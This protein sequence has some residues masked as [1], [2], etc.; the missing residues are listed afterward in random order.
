MH[1][2]CTGQLNEAELDNQGLQAQLEDMTNRH[3]NLTTAHEQTTT[4]K[5]ELASAL[6]QEQATLAAA[7]AEVEACRSQIEELNVQLQAAQSSAGALGE[8]ESSLRKQLA[9]VQTA[10]AEKEGH[11]AAAQE[12]AQVRAW[13]KRLVGLFQTLHIQPLCNTLCLLGEQKVPSLHNQL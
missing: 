11:L 7:S 2:C 12:K 9:D 4:E 5:A 1:K 3:S 8:L 10:L 6:Q 13:C